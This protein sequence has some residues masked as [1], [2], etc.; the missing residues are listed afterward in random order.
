MYILLAVPP[1]CFCLGQPPPEFLYLDGLTDLFLSKI[2]DAH[3]LPGRAFAPIVSATVQQ[4]WVWTKP[5]ETETETPMP[6][7]ALPWERA[8]R[9][10]S[11]AAREEEAASLAAAAAAAAT[12]DERHLGGTGGTAAT[13]SGGSSVAIG[14]RVVAVAGEH[15]AAK[16]VGVVRARQDSVRRLLCA[17]RGGC[18]EDEAE[19]RRARVV[20]LWGPDEV[21]CGAFPCTKRCVYVVH[22]VS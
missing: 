3:C 20:P 1:V 17:I 22:T 12:L 2:R 13:A 18:E 5:G 10:G 16:G 7:P 9:G 4:S 11:G 6:A 19:E 21:R 8:G 14:S 15:G